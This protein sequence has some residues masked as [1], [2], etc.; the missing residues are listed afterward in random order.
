V[1]AL[2]RLILAGYGLG[3]GALSVIALILPQPL[4]LET[5]GHYLLPGA[6]LMSQLH[7]GARLGLALV[8]LIAAQMPRPARPLVVAVA[9][10]LLASVVGPVF[11]FLTHAI[12]W[13]ELRGVR[14]GL[15]LDG[16]I[17]AV[18]LATTIARSR[19]RAADPA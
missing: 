16:M 7:A 15:I 5:V 17:A 10:G 14:T 4:A 1:H 13:P 12:P 9:L 19:L 6:L 18:L 8:A 3:A 11:S 2:E